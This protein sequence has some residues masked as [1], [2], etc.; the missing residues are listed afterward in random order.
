MTAISI[1]IQPE[2]FDIAAEVERIRA[3]NGG[4]GA[5]VTFSGIC[6]DENGSLTALE[7]EHYPGMAEA[8]IERIAK[9]TGA[10][11]RAV[12]QWMGITRMLI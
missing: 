5:I 6:R 8:E 12:V 2:D 10:R 7:L 4:V 3:T 9:E 11:W 1:R